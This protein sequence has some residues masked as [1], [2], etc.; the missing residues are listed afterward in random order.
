MAL[1]WFTRNVFEV[2]EII[3][4]ASAEWVS[5]IADT[6][7]LTVFLMTIYM[8]IFGRKKRP[9]PR[10]PIT[11]ATSNAF[12]GTPIFSSPYAPP[13]QV[14]VMNPSEIQK[15]IDSWPSSSD[16]MYRPQSIDNKHLPGC[17]RRHDPAATC[18]CGERGFGVRGPWRTVADTS[19]VEA[20]PLRW[21]TASAFGCICPQGE[22]EGS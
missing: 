14:I 18:I 1:G 11:G 10:T 3:F 5:T 22:S 12:T 19:H 16:F 4:G 9:A 21:R 20:C 13:G 6:V 2:P 17:R 7:T 8:L 15:L